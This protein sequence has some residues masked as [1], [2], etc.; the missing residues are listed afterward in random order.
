MRAIPAA[1]AVL[2][3]GTPVG[4]VALAGAELWVLT[5]HAP[6]SARAIARRP[7]PTKK[8]RREGI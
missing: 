5:N 7:R 8:W 4:G 3:E 6:R 1:W 2:L